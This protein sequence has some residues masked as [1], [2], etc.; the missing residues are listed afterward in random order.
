[1]S[2]QTLFLWF[3]AFRIKR[4]QGGL[5]TADPLIVSL[6]ITNYLTLNAIFINSNENIYFLP[7]Q[8]SEC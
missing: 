3:Q 6:E 4:E 1:M 8:E 7:S 2:K 5:Y